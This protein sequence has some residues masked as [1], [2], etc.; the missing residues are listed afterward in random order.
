MSFSGNLGNDPGSK[1]LK[2]M[3][4]GSTPEECFSEKNFVATWT[5]GAVEIGGVIAAHHNIDP[6]AQAKLMAAFNS[7]LT[8]ASTSS[9]AI[10]SI[11]STL[12]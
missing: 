4:S 9:T 3:T 7:T 2:Q 12:N 6:D 10:F 8:F 11:V 5:T 1:V